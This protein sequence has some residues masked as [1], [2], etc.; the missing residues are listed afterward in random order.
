MRDDFAIYVLSH[1]RAFNAGT[2]EMLAK[3]GYTGKAFVVIDDEDDIDDYIKCYGKDKVL[4]F[5]KD[6]YM[7]KYDA[8]DNLHKR[9]IAFY[10]R[11]FINE[12][13]IKSGLTYYGQFDDDILKLFHRYVDENGKF[14]RLEVNN[15][16][17]IFTS[18]LEFMDSSDCIAGCCFALDSGYFGGAGG[19]FKN[20]MGRKIYQTMLL[21][22]SQQV[23]WK[24]S[25][26]EDML[27]STLNVDKLYFDVYMNS[28]DSPKMSTN[29]GGINY[30]SI[31]DATIY[32]KVALGEKFTLY[33]D[34]RTLMRNDYLFPKIVSSR[35]KL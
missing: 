34:G 9:S 33:P 1:K 21:K 15:V 4:I 11:N 27:L 16:D 28:F 20:G 12:H 8:M 35:F 14:Q 30:S 18:Y 7:D 17:D 2:M 24:G 19:K 31:F 32:A 6:S 23:P 13:A 26:L 5:N 10:A 22:V 25:H 29:D 3:Y